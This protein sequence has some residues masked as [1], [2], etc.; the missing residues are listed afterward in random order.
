MYTGLTGKVSIR[1][2]TTGAGNQDTQN[3]IEHDVAYISNWSIESSVEIIE[4]AELGKPTRKKKAGLRGW[5]ASADGTVFF[6]GDGI[7]GHRAL[8]N[9]MNS[10]QEVRCEF[11]LD[12]G[13]V[14]PARPAVGFF[15]TGLIESLSVDLSAEDKGS[16]SISISGIGD[17]SFLPVAPRPTP[18]G[19]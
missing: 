2:I 10:G 13:S 7:S 12:V 6:G 3:G 1:P 14:G 5:T 8:F 9:A 16:I 19:Q 15:G 18:P 11:F 17:M 4:N